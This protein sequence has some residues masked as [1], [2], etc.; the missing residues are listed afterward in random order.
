MYFEERAD[1]TRDKKVW[2]KE[3]SQN[4][5]W[6]FRPGVQLDDVD[7]E[8]GIWG[9]VNWGAE[10]LLIWGF[11]WPQWILKLVNVIYLGFSSPF[12]QQDLGASSTSM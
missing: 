9:A 4:S 7:A 8:M 1:L 2:G 10:N 6:G 11:C 3:K 12:L 5:L